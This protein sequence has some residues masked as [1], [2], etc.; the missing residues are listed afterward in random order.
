MKINILKQII[1][2]EI[3]YYLLNEVSYED[4][5]KNLYTK[6]TKSVINQTLQNFK[7][8]LEP[9]EYEKEYEKI[10]NTIIKQI[11]E[12]IDDKQKGLSL[13]WLLRIFRKYGVEEFLKQIV[14]APTMEG[15]PTNERKIPYMLERFFH[16]K[17]FLSE[18]D[19]NK[20]S[21]LEELYYVLE[22]ADENIKKHQSE[23][24]KQKKAKNVDLG[25]EVLSN[26]KNWFIALLHNKG[27]ACHWGRNTDWCT[28]A[29]GLNYF[30]E[31]YTPND[32]LIY[33]ENKTT[34]EKFQFQFGSHQFMN[35]RDV[36]VSDKQMFKLLKLLWLNTDQNFYK[37][38]PKIKN[39]LF[40][41]LVNSEFIDA[42]TLYELADE[43]AYAN[44][45]Y[46]ELYPN[47]HWDSYDPDDESERRYFRHWSA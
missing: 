33:F 24:E 38:Y 21:S 13:M 2:K 34:G 40:R 31:Y 5:K 14:F 45:R 26:S 37:K 36:E 7:T 32:P 35:S 46:E 23:Q 6:K 10:I 41:R 3:K 11:P 8:P 43:N 18:K 47:G 27:A 44:E 17:R 22:A 9:E 29:P 15:W 1:K 42:D 19:L 16:W 25:T 12:D 20:I 39:D 4:A 28:A 30:E